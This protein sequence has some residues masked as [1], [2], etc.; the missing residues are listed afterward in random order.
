MHV[1]YQLQSISVANSPESSASTSK[2]YEK[3]FISLVS[4][5]IIVFYLINVLS[6]S[7]NIFSSPFFSS[8]GE[9]LD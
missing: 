8:L 5:L 9:V 1:L 3:F 4:M 7:Q 2:H 6:E